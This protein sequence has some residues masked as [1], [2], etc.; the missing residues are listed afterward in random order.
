MP[1]NQAKNLIMKYGIW[2]VLN[3]LLV[4][5]TVVLAGTFALEIALP[6]TLTSGG[7]ETASAAY[8]GPDAAT[9]IP[10]P[11]TS[12]SMI[13]LRLI[14]SGLF[15]PSTGV[16]KPMADKTI[17]KIKSRLKLQ[18][19][20][21]MSGEKVAYIHIKGIGLKKCSVGD[22]IEDLFTVININKKDVEL[23]IIEHKV[24]LRM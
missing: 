5:G 2:R 16:S 24:T 4:V 9:D 12:N 1:A 20:M 11:T 22:S 15:K 14:R 3:T 23:S 7:S 21:E 10:Q 18:C 6:V 19:V 13:D 8:T 17:Q